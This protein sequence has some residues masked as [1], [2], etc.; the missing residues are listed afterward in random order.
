MNKKISKELRRISN[1]I[2]AELKDNILIKV[3][4]METTNEMYENALK[5]KD[6][7]EATLKK[8]Q[9][10][11]DGGYLDETEFIENDE[12]IKKINDYL[13]EQI[14]LSIKLGRLPDKEELQKLINKTKKYVRKNNK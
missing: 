13:E 3:R 4:K 14:N 8:L 5:D 1:S 10:L 12:V 9:M 7:S 2:P 6:V 11:K